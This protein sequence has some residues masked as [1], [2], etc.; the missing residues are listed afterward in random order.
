MFV[1]EK[2]DALSFVTISQMK[3]MS[4][5]SLPTDRAE[6]SQLES[7]WKAVVLNSVAD[8]MSSKSP[9]TLNLFFLARKFI[10]YPQERKKNCKQAKTS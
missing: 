3:G 9:L 4:L 10:L 5:G 7:S 1:W 2:Q 8:E 6:K